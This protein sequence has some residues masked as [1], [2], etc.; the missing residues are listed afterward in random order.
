VNAIPERASVYQATQ[1]GLEAPSTPGTVVP[2]TKRIL[3]FMV[4]ARPNVPVP[5][6]HPQGSRVATT[7][8]AQKEW[9]SGSLEGVIG[10][11]SI[12]YILNSLLKTV[13]PTTPAGATLQRLHTIK[14]ATFAP[15][16]FSTFTIEKGS[17]VAAERF[18]FG[19]FE[20]LTLRVNRTEAA[21]SGNVMGQK[22]S[23]FGTDGFTVMSSPTDIP[24]LPVDPRAVSVFVGNTF[25]VNEVQT[26]AING[27]TGTY[28]ITYDGQSTAPIAV[29]ATTAAVQSALQ[30]LSNIGANNVT[31][32]G[33]P[34]TSYT[35][36]FVGALAGLDVSSLVLSA[37]TGGPPT[38]VVTTPGG[39][40]KLTR[41]SSLELVIPAAYNYGFTVNQ[42]DPSYSFVVQKDLDATATLVLEH[43]SVSAALMA[44]LR[45]RTTKY[46]CILAN[47]PAVETLISI[48][49]LNQ[50]RIF[51]PFRFTESDRGDVEDVFA[52]T[53]STALLY[54][55]TFNGWLQID[56]YNGL[57]SL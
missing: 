14:P 21:I 13:T 38:I 28:V 44:D 39:L 15:D 10:F 11:Q 29:A 51:F 53:Y 36:T 17:S 37:F 48:P 31:V 41:V 40:T 57:A 9:T 20:S 7:N 4:S 26:L 50:L 30:G 49:Y 22:T 45:N 18:A 54:D 1:L 24:A 3:D 42:S 52:N 55:T 16:N 43:D 5:I 47:G 12:V 6:F 32:A 34:G 33:T 19:I 46:C 27:A 56:A 8:L 35:I 2:A 23:E 25:S